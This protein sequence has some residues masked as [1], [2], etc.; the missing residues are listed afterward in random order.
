MDRRTCLKTLGMGAAAWAAESQGKPERSK[1]NIVF[2]L[3]DDLGYG[4]PGCY[5]SQKIPT[6][7]MDALAAQGMRFTDAHSGSAVCT[8]TR[9]GI[10]TGR[11]CWR[12][13]LKRGVL[14]GYSEPLIEEGRLT[15]PALL[16]RHGYHTGC[17]GKWHLGMEWTLR[18]PPAGTEESNIDFAAP[19]KRGPRSYGFDRYFGIS[20]SLDMP[21]Y[22]YID[23]DSAAGA[24]TAYMEKQGAV[25]AG[26]REPGF[27]TVDVMPTLTR[28]AVEYVDARG[29]NPSQ[30]FFLYFPLT[31]PHTPVVPAEQ[32]KGKSAAGDYGDFVVQ[33][34]WTLGEI[35][36]ALDRNRLAENTLLIMTSDNGSTNPVMTEFDHR[37]NGPWRGRK[38]D[39]WDGGHREPFL[40]RWPG[41]IKAGAVSAEL[42]CLGDLMATCAEIVGAKLPDGAGEDSYSILPAL[43][44]TAGGKP[45]REAV[46]HH[47]IEGTFAVRQGPWKLVLGRGSGGWSSQ[48]SPQDPEGQLYNLESDPGEME[49]LYERRPD[50]VKRLTQLLEKYKKEGR[51]RPRG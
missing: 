26:V 7:N 15:V 13:R 47:S 10:L 34:D 38:S 8:P 27:R 42:I 20:A 12:T 5:G 18:N 2:I 4:D 17:V 28:K 48:G 11:Y 39:A 44:G 25:R 3:A 19:V 21:P 30:P 37:P 14:L 43:L 32:F 16:K 1:P 33:T 45:I 24:P 49:S 29:K 50:I 31:S 9:Y 6:P 41:K 51:S 46:I 36:K 23:G 40:A 35:M 22:V